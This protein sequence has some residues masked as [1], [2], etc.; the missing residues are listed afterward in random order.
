MSINCA[1]IM[2]RLTKDAELKTT[3]NG[4]N[5]TRFTVAVDRPTKQ[6]EE[7]KAD[8][9]SCIAWR[10]TAEFICRNFSKGKLIAISGKIE[11]GSYTNQDGEKVY[12]TEI[13][14]RDISFCGDYGSKT[15][16]SNQN[17]MER[18]NNS[19]KHNTGF[20]NATA[21]DDGMTGPWWMYSAEKAVKEA[22]AE[23]DGIPLARL[24]DGS[25]GLPF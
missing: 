23:D 19:Y 2:G 15:V 1:I 25:D 13:V 5:Y 18:N 20:S 22:Q 17:N 24:I 4:I 16:Q 7:K 21:E 8:F 14:A 9:I 11:T 3:N 6:G 12:T 10:G